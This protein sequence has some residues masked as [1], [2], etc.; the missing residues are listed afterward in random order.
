MNGQMVAIQFNKG[1]RLKSSNN[2]LK[3]TGKQAAD[4][5]S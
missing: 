3:I 1:V 5:L 4:T 2:A